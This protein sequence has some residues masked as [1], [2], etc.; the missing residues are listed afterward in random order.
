MPCVS[1]LYVDVKNPAVLEETNRLAHTDWPIAI[2]SNQILVV[3][4]K[5]ALGIGKHNKFHVKALAITVSQFTPG[6]RSTRSTHCRTPWTL[7]QQPSRGP[8][9][10]QLAHTT[11]TVQ[12]LENQ[13]TNL[14][15]QIQSLDPTDP[16][17]APC[18]TRTKV[19]WPSSS[20]TPSS[21]SCICN[22]EDRSSPATA[23]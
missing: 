3:S 2:L 9:Q 16:M 11:A 10:Q 19:S 20:P 15:S 14:T 1:Q 23:C 6:A 22:W 12:S 21:S 5:A 18:S 17:R 13:L 8:V 4:G 7:P